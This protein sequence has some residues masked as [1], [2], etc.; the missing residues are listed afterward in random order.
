MSVFSG[1]ISE[2][3]QS[4]QPVKMFWMICCLFMRTPVI[5]PQNVLD[6]S[7]EVVQQK[8]IFH[9]LQMEDLVTCSSPVFFNLGIAT[10]C[11]VTWNS[12]GV[13]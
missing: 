3:P 1:S 6:L 4:S 5:F 8:M 7:K 12:N 10:A 11:G 13:A 2:Q 9:L